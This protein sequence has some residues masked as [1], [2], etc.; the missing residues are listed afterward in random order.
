MQT[1]LGAGGIIGQELSK[2]LPQYTEQI[3]QVSRQPTKVNPSDELFACDLTDAERVK[4][5]VKGSEVAYLVA[6]LPYNIKVWQTTWPV[7]MK[8]VITACKLHHCK[9]VFFDNVYMYDPRHIPHMTEDTP[10]NPSSEKGK[11]RAHI[12]QMLMNEVQ[13]GSLQAL[14]ARAADFYGPHNT[15]SMLIETVFKSL[16][17]GKKANWLGKA[18]Y[19]HSFTFTPDAG[20]AT[21]LLGNTPDAY[22][23]VWHLPTAAE[24]PTGK[25]WVEG[26]A[27]EMQVAPKYREVGKGM[28]WVL[29]LFNGLMKELLEMLYQYDRDYVFDSSKFE[30][31]FDFTP[32]SYEEGIRQTVAAD[33]QKKA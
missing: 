22:G 29:G 24:P 32:T 10:I 15:T 20:K 19:K 4:E 18:N 12:Y 21:A 28:V 14:V 6:G 1:L 16:K 27:R 2:I 17:Q 33:Y 23:Q 5:A 7:V 8:N 9:L 31:Y 25:E 30:K 13:E 3:R 11:V 26:F